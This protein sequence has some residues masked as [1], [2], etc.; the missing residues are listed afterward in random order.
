LQG[1][2]NRLLWVDLAATLIT[3]T[4]VGAIATLLVNRLIRSLTSATD[5][6]QKLGQG[7]LDARVNIQGD[8]ELATLGSNINQMA[9]QLQALLDQKEADNRRATILKEATL[10]MAQAIKLEEVLSVAVEE[11]RQGLKTDRVL[12]YRFDDKGNGEVIEESV[13]PSFPYAFNVQ[14]YNSWLTGN[15]LSQY[16][17]GQTQAIP[18]IHEANLTEQHIKQ[19]ESLSVKAALVAPIRMRRQLF[20][21]LIAHQCSEPRPW[22]PAE[23]TLFSQIAAQ[24]GLSCNQVLLLEQTQAVQHLAEGRSQDQFHQQAA[25]LAELDKLTMAAEIAAD[26]D[27]TTRAESGQVMGQMSG[28]LNALID[29]FR[30]M[31]VEAKRATIQIYELINRDTRG[32]NQLAETVS[33]QTHHLSQQSALM[34]QLLR[35]LQT[36]ADQV[37]RLTSV[38]A[39]TRETAEIGEQTVQGMTQNLT[40]FQEQGH[41]VIRRGSDLTDSC[42]QITRMIT[43]INQT[44]LRIN[45][46]AVNASLEAAN[47][48]LENQSLI[49]IAQEMGQLAERLRFNTQ[50]IEKMM[51][52]I[53]LELNAMMGDVQTGV[54]QTGESN[55]LVELIKQ[56]WK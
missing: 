6:V 14:L 48:G 8:H 24:I 30:Q 40:A 11:A 47:K 50:E 56:H 42:Q 43:S 53:Q 18:N 20:G 4:L 3:A 41:Q 31:V 19:L 21:L 44:A 35:S 13:N 5:T 34:E 33:Q 51:E 36:A 10:R 28:Q 16:Q 55:Q 7:N 1:A 27:L 17:Q 45:L 54:N 2:E 39:N 9:D 29:R 12:I 38:A 26:G 37:Q 25:F 32:L 22:E 49:V 15:E 46:L 23:V 52:G